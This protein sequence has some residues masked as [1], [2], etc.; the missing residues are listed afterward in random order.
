M[1][2]MILVVVFFVGFIVVPVCIIGKAVEE[3][4]FNKDEDDWDGSFDDDTGT[5]DLPKA[6]LQWPWKKK[7]TVEDDWLDMLP[8]GFDDDFEPILPVGTHSKTIRTVMPV[9]SMTR[10]PRIIGARFVVGAYRTEVYTTTD[11]GVEHRLF[12]YYPDEVS[13]GPGD[14]GGLT[15]AQAKQEHRAWAAAQIRRG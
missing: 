6:K 11:D 12:S 9:P 7:S 14:F 2:E 15:V 4:L 10:E 8:T 3:E 1:V 5:V 13:Y